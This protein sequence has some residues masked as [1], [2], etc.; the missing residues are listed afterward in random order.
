MRQSISAE[1]LSAWW[2]PGRPGMY[3]LCLVSRGTVGNC[4]VRYIK[5]SRHFPLRS[6]HE[7]ARVFRTL[8]ALN[9]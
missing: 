3:E 4:R 9:N 2:L 7:L 8:D 1:G 5:E 6:R